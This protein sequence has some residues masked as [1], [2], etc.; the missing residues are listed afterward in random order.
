MGQRHKLATAEP[1]TGALLGGQGYAAGE[2]LQIW[3][4]MEQIKL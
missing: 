3:F 1:G 2:I 4:E